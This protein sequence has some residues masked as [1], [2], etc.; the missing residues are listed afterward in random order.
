MRRLRWYMERDGA[1]LL[2]M[3]LPAR[4]AAD[5]AGRIT[6]AYRTT[7]THRTAQFPP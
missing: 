7:R 3:L 4:D 2:D 1:Y 5:F 6:Y